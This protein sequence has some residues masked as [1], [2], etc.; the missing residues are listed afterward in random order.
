MNRFPVSS[1]LGRLE[2]AR[3]N[4]LEVMTRLGIRATLK[5]PDRLVRA[6]LGE[7]WKE[8]DQM[9]ESTLIEAASY[10]ERLAI[11]FRPRDRANSLKRFGAVLLAM[12]A[13]FLADSINTPAEAKRSVARADSPFQVR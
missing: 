6:H 9:D 3:M 2:A 11:E 12:S 4:L 5:T 8:P 13:I 10:L 7:A 1:A